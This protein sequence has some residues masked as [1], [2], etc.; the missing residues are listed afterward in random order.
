MMAPPLTKMGESAVQKEFSRY[1][2][3]VRVLF[4]KSPRAIPKG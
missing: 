4:K 3:R 1:P 2:Q